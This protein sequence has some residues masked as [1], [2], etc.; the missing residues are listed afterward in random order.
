MLRGIRRLDI[1]LKTF[2]LEKIIEGN[3]IRIVTADAY[4]AEKKALVD[5]RD[6][7]G[8]AEEVTTKVFVVNN[9][10]LDKLR[11][12][13]DKGKIL[14]PRGSISADSRTRSLI[15]KDIPIAL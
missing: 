10:N 15:V 11:E 13:V 9:A 12:A 5:S 2:N 7:V 1:I 4:Q 3:V 14:S 8:R 6:I